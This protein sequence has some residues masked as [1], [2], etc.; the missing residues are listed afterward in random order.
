VSSLMTLNVLARL[1]SGASDALRV[2]IARWTTVGAGVAAY[3]IAS[4]GQSII[5]LIQLTSAFG[6][7]GILVAVMFGL[8]SGYGGP[9]AAWW[10]ILAC[11]VVNVWTLFVDPTLKLISSGE[12]MPLGDA[13][14]NVLTGGDEAADATM[15]GYFL[16]SLAASALAYVA[17]A[18]SERKREPVS[19][20]S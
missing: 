4:T 3:L 18:E 5:D 17:G 1:H 16:L 19:S 9:R 11:L 6:Q 10:A 2:R 8:W 12:A 13:V 14:W 7:A 20:P 15:E